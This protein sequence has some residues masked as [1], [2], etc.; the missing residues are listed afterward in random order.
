MAEYLF[1]H[2]L[3]KRLECTLEELAVAGYEVWSAGTY[4]LMGGEA[5]AGAQAEMSQRGIGVGGHRTQPLTVELIQQAERIW[6]MS[7]EH[8]SAVLDLAPGAAG[9]VELLDPDGPV[10]DPMGAG[11]D[12]YRRCAAHIERMVEARLEEFLNED[13]NW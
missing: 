6:V 9:R 4:A 13:R 10:A 7:S 11:A 1:R 2:K 5:S 8:R 12:E 3:A